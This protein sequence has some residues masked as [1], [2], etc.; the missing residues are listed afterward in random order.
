[1]RVILYYRLRDE[2]GRWRADGCLL[3]PIHAAHYNNS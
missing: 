2:I 1:M 3:R